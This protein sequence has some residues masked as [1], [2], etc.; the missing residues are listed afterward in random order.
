MRF[1]HAELAVVAGNGL[2]FIWGSDAG[3]VLP[4][5]VVKLEGL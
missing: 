5:H 1:M 3:R 2:I 4:Y